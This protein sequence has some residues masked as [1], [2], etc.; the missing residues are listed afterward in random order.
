Q[1]VLGALAARTENERV[2]ETLLVFCIALRERGTRRVAGGAGAGLF[3]LRPPALARGQ[4]G[5]GTRFA[6]P[7]MVRDRLAELGVR[8]PGPGTVG[9]GE[10]PIAI[11]PRAC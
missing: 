1:H 6:E 5:G 9:S 8:E 10:Q 7:R 4:A 11:A 2:P 3:A